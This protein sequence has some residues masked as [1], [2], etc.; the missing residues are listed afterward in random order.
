[1]AVLS[2]TIFTQNLVPP[3]DAIQPLVHHY[4]IAF[5]QIRHCSS[6]L[7]DHSRDLVSE[8]LRLQRERYRLAIFVGVVVRVTSEDV[9]VSAAQTNRS[10]AYQN[11]IWRYNRPRYVSHLEPVHV[12]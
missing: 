10:D 2:A 4:A 8:N 9:Y 1:M 6:D 12:A 7:F 3:A 5:A 11:F